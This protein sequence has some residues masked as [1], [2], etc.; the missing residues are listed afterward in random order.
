ME[1]SGRNQWQPVRAKHPVNKPKPRNRCLGCHQLPMGAHGK[2]G[3]NGSSPLEGSATAPPLAGLFW[4]AE[5]RGR[6]M[7]GWLRVDAEH[8]Q[9][10]QRLAEWVERGIE[11]PRSLPPK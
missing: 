2:E 3:V 5:M 10:R 8:V 11:F 6:I 7:A 4:P 1:P 9:T